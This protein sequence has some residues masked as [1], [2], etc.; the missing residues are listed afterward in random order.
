MHGKV[1]RGVLQELR[2]CVE[3]DTCVVVDKMHKYSK[4]RSIYPG[5]KPEVVLLPHT[6]LEISRI[7]KVCNKHRIPVTTRGAGTGL[8]GGAI[9]LAGGVVLSTEKLKKI[10]IDSENM[11]AD[12]GAGVYKNELNKAL[13]K[14]GLVLGPDPA[15]NPT[16][17]GMV[18]TSGSGLSTL[19]Y[20]TTRENVISLIVVTPSGEIIKTRQK[21][22]KASTGYELTQLY[23]GSEGTLGVVTE[24]CIRVH[25]DQ[26][27]RAGV[28][29]HFP[30][31]K[32]AAEAVVTMLKMSRSTLVRCE[33]LNA[34][35]IECTNKEYKTSLPYAPTLFLE[36][37]SNDFKKIQSEWREI[38][39][40][41]EKFGAEGI[42]YSEDAKEFESLW[43]ARRGCYF[44]TMKYRKN[45]QQQPKLDKNY[46]TD[47]CVP[48]SNLAECISETEDDFGSIGFPC[49]ICAHIADGNFH[50]MIPYQ[51]HEKTRLK[52]A[53]QRLIERAV[54]VGGAVSGEHGVGLGKKKH[55]CLEHGPNHIAL[56]AR[57]KRALDPKLIMNPHKIFDVS[58]T[59]ENG[60]SECKKSRQSKL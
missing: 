14:K 7:M 34:K 44:S 1:T 59:E 15:S 18:S 53:E 29:C 28:V 55:I 43:S 60:A 54:R 9:P 24:V 32:N 12:V 2:A 22:R 11:H 42:R 33:L 26:P 17:G 46:I 23:I 52:E 48:V 40:T 49:L 16:L 27:C 41:F 47:V 36:F 10:S 21:V 25:V 51:P 3:H 39:K 45:L 38:K 5:K 58:S 37:Q 57:I 35:M 20:G 6:T 30:R 13:K 8:E 4:D 19:R 50:C 56:Q 31:I